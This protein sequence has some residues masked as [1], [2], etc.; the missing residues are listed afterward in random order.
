TD[1]HIAEARVFDPIGL[2]N[3]FARTIRRELNFAREGRTMDEF[4]R[5]F[6][7]DPTLSIPVVYWELTTESILTMEFIEGLR[8]DQLNPTHACQHSG[9]ELAARGAKIFMKQAFVFGVFHGDP[10]PGNIRVRP[11]GTICLLDYGM[12]GMLETATR[13]QLVDLF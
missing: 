7:G 6:R 8:I 11:D 9:A 5:L 4:R 2:V 1:R 3:H 12:V 13:E 10:H